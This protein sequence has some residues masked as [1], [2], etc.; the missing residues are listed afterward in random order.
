MLVKE[1]IN[2]QKFGRKERMPLNK[3][4]LSSLITTILI[5]SILTLPAPT[6][7]AATYPDLIKTISPSSGKVK[8]TVTVTGT[9]PSDIT[10]E[11]PVEIYWSYAEPTEAT[12]EGYGYENYGYGALGDGWKLLTTVTEPVTGKTKDYIAKVEVPFTEAGKIYIIAWQDK[13]NINVIDSGEWDYAEFTILKG[14]TLEPSKGAVGTELTVYGSGFTKGGKVDIY[15]D[16]DKD[17]HWEPGELQVVGGSIG[18]D[19]TFELDFDVPTVEKGY[20]SYTVYATD[21]VNTDTA[22]FTVGPPVI[23]ISPKEGGAGT[24]ITVEVNYFTV[25]IDDELI[26]LQV[27]FDTNNNEVPDADDVIASKTLNNTGGETFSIGVPSGL[28]YG[29]YKIVALNELDEKAVATFTV[30][31]KDFKIT[32]SDTSAELSQGTLATEVATVTVEAISGFEGTVSLTATGQPTGVTVTFDKSSVSLDAT[33]TSVTTG[34]KIAVDPTVALGTYT[35]TVKGKSGGTVHTAKFTLKV[36]APE[37]TKPLDTLISK[38][39]SEYDGSPIEEGPIGVNVVVNGTASGKITSDTP[40]KIY[41]SADLDWDKDDKL[42][43]TV[44]EPTTGDTYYEATVTIPDVNDYYEV[45]NENVVKNP[46]DSEKGYIV[47]TYGNNYDSAEFTVKSGIYPNAGSVGDEVAVGGWDHAN[48]GGKI[49]IYWDTQAPE[50]KLAEVW[51]KAG[52]NG[53]YSATITVPE[54]VKGTY[55]IIVVDSVKGQLAT[56]TFTLNPKITLSP[57]TAIQGDIITVEGT[58]F[59]AES[60]ITLTLDGEEL[61]TTPT[62]VETD[63]YGS[64]TCTFKVSKDLT[65]GTYWVTAEDEDGNSDDAKLTIGPAITLDPIRPNRNNR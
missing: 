60:A 29:E 57:S 46:K 13:D 62:D 15:F 9:A 20:A 51:S 40:V 3:K 2:Q 52:Y 61:S 6:A 5:I 23:S 47:V 54:T 45:E 34:M 36:T 12:V 18:N 63:E 65:T 32:L 19:G 24:T 50:N 37:P 58:G 10:P 33:T 17:S 7:Q 49:L 14:I 39:V 42:L 31:A 55:S 28:S 22:L 27:F 26:P 30:L 25:K 16:A 35:I 56:Y 53:S 43:V 38:V 64:F 1:K 59:A 8:T 4:I 48:P 11:H 21:G 44:E 41:W